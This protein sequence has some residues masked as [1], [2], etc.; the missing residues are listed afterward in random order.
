MT[1]ALKHTILGLLATLLAISAACLL[2]NP[3]KQA[4]ADSTYSEI[5][6]IKE[7]WDYSK[8]FSTNINGRVSTGSEQES[9]RTFTKFEILNSSGTIFLNCG[10]FAIS[11]A[12]GGVRSFQNVP[13]AQ[14][15]S[16][17]EWITDCG[18]VTFYSDTSATEYSELRTWLEANA[19]R[20]D[21]TVVFKDGAT[22]L[23][24]VTVDLGTK[25]SEIDLSDLK[26]EK[27]GYKF[28]GWSKTEGGD[29]IDLEI[30]S[31]NEYTVLYAVYEKGTNNILDNASEWLTTKTGIAFSATGVLVLALGV[32]LLLRRK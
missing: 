17:D 10:S 20:F 1:K 5:W 7:D 6:I 12:S 3:V 19:T 29:V 31:V 18:K 28:K 11:V 9:N 4:K 14:N 23:K 22:S 32:Y 25:A 8:A 13:Q 26:L 27:N 16:Y 2:T 21:C 30:V 15:M 24:T